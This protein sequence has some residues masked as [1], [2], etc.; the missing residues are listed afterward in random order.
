M[1][2]LTKVIIYGRYYMKFIKPISILLVICTVCSMF[3][4]S[5]KDDK[6]KPQ[7]ESENGSNAASNEDIPFYDELKKVFKDEEM[8][9]LSGK[10]YEG[11]T[12]TFLTCGVNAEHESEIVFN[13]YEDGEQCSLPTVINEDI[14]ERAEMLKQILGIEVKENY[15]FDPRRRNADMANTIRQG[16]LINTDEFQVVVPCLYDG[17]TLAVDGQLQNLLK[18]PGLQMD[19]PWWDQNF[20]KEMTYGDQLY[21]TIGDIGIINKNSTAVLYFNYDMWMNLK[22]E[23]KYG[24]TPYELVRNKKWDLDTVAEV[25][26]NISNDLNHD[27]VID[28]KDEFGWGGQL[29]VMWSIFYGS[30]ERIA[31]ADSEG[32]PMLTIYNE[33]SAK[34]MEKL[35]EFVQDKKSY[36]SANDYFGV[37]QWPSVLVEQAFMEGRCMFYNGALGTVMGLGNMEQH[38][39]IVPVPMSTSD[40][41]NYNSLVNPWTTTCFAI[42]AC[43][44]GDDL[45]MTV[46][47][48]NFLGAM[49][50]ITV[51]DSYYEIAIKNMKTRDD[52]SVE[53]IDKYI[54]PSRGCDVGLVFAWGGFD[55]LLHTMASNPVGTFASEVESKMEMAQDALDET[56]EFFKDNA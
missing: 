15:V 54:L 50:N 51:A 13:T 7:D 44:Q 20:N 34:V 38:F 1:L 27:E 21:Y 55:E 4:F 5:C 17:A 33:R 37:V 52:E 18:V 32:Y 42:P 45:T 39:G 36:I 35:Q 22:L 12:V 47:A 56:I 49:S 46:D 28:Y 10:T 8:P 19:K 48:L 30:G 29:D 26:K 25:T 9:K 11:R 40:Q 3:L 2:K 23:E 16:N 41:D 53:M 14:K 24:G 6:G 31:S 43:V